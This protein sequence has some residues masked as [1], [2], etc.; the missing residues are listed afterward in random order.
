[1]ERW[2]NM[3]GLE[4]ETTYNFLMYSTL[5]AFLTMML[6]GAFMVYQSFHP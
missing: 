5:T 2:I 3:Q 4:M 1:M 6:V